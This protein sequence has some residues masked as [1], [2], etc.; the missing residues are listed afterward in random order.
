MSEPLTPARLQQLQLLF[1]QALE[2]SPSQRGEF[3][4][5]ETG[6]DAAL[7][8]EVLALLAAHDSS[9]TAL[10]RPVN[11]AS[12]GANGADASRWLGQRL[13]PWRVTRLI[14]FGGM[15]TVCEAERAD[16]QF[17]K[18]VAIKFLHRHARIPS[19]VERFRAERQI[20]ANLDHPNIATLLD[21]GVTDDGQPYLVMEYIDGQSITGWVETHDLTRR[22]RVELFLQVC[23]AVEGAHR[24]LIVH[25]DLKPGNVLV[26]QDGRVKLLDFGIARLLDESAPEFVATRGSEPLS[27]TP[28]YAAPEQMRALPVSTATDVFALGVILYQLLTDR[29]PFARRT[30][31]E[32]VATAAGLGPDLDA[33]LA[34]ALES[35][36][37]RR[38]PTV[39]ALRTDL[40]HWL[41]GEPVTAHPDT[42]TYRLSKFVGRH[43]AGVVV[44]ALAMSLILVASGAAL[45]QAR[46][47]RAAAADMREWN[48]FLMDVLRMSNPF[49]EGDELTLAAAL[50][51]AAEQIDTRFATRPDLSAE[52]RFGIGS[53]MVDRYRLDQAETQLGRAL[54]D[55]VAVFGANDIRTLRVEESI[56]G[57][58][59]EQSRYRDA[60]QGYQRVIA[61]LEGERMQAD[62]L[63]TRA[64]G[65]LGYLYLIEERYPEADRALRQSREFDQRHKSMDDLDRAV[66]LSNLAHAAHGLEDLDS[67]DQYYAEAEDAYAAQFPDGSPDF[68]ILLNNRASVQEARNQPAAALALYQRSLAMRRRVF[69]GEHP[70]IVVALSSV[71]RLSAATGDPAGALSAAIEAARMADRV[72]TAPNRFHPSVYATL[73]AAQLANSDLRGATTSLQTSLRLLATI[74]DPPPSVVRWVE[75]V[76]ADLCTQ[77]DTSTNPPCVPR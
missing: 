62:R 49:G 34:H 16:E 9:A 37:Q 54:A 30:N 38:Y 42:T 55:S 60:E 44:G 17:E 53:S 63:F 7:R 3:L 58:R 51:R 71:A 1:E 5:R 25:R 15:G 18:R 77:P 35:D 66:L 68:A 74:E 36:P 31:P 20:L 47:A 29:L 14:G 76:R 50:D 27:F 22:A 32:A 26:S 45:W 41:S 12:L 75:R 24:Q 10:N 65:N 28:D 13:G 21:G 39:Q 64:L 19:A 8:D 56:A 43:R 61:V 52:I 73:A 6:S 59:V 33:V 70:M 69:A 11:L 4:E 72:Y 46:L 23:A 40:E 67:A 2:L 48:S 57:L